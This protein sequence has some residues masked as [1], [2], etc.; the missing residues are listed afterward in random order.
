M[1]IADTNAVLSETIDRV[2]Y[3]EKYMMDT[4]KRLDAMQEMLNEVANRLRFIESIIC[5]TP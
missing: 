3:I 2:R 5:K 1:P 4:E